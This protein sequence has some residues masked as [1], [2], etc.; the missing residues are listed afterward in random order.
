MPEEVICISYAYD[1]AL[2]IKGRNEER[3]RCS[4]TPSQLTEEQK[5]QLAANKTEVS[6]IVARITVDS[7][8]IEVE[9]TTITTIQ[10][11]KYL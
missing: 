10:S 6:I 8:E 4:A 5:L 2:L 1:L 9:H 11:L 7:V 3:L